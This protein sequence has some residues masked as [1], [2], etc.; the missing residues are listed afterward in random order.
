LHGQQRHQRP[1]SSG[2]TIATGTAYQQ[3]LTLAQQGQYADFDG[4]GAGLNKALGAYAGAASQALQ[5]GSSMEAGR[6][7]AGK[8][9]DYSNPVKAAQEEY[10]KIDYS[11]LGP[12]YDKLV[13]GRAQAAD[14]VASQALASVAPPAPF[15]DAGPALI[16]A[17]EAPEDESL[18]DKATD[19][20]FDGMKEGSDLS[21]KAKALDKILD[22]TSAVG[23]Q[24]NLVGSLLEAANEMGSASQSTESTDKLLGQ[25]DQYSSKVEQSLGEQNPFKALLG[26]D[27]E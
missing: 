16:D 11:V 7:L 15:P 24:R 25:L 6:E 17:A 10:L 23:Q 8:D 20:L 19:S 5:M 2:G 22:I 4:R 18:I 26:A 13:D 1:G 21:P 27:Q 9:L 3:L 12:K 14:E